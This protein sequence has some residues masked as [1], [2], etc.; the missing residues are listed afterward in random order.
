[1]RAS[2]PT[3][4]GPTPATP[5]A[6]APSSASPSSATLATATPKAQRKFPAS[7]TT[8]PGRPS[9]WPHH[10]SPDHLAT[11]RGHAVSWFREN[12]RDLPMRRP[13]VSAWG[14]VVFEVMSQQ[15]PIPRVQPVWEKWMERWPTPAALAQARSG[16]ILVAWDRLGYPSRALRL[17]ECASYIVEHCEGTVPALVDDLLQLPGIGPY[18]ASA[19][20]SFHY[21]QRVPVLDTNVRRVLGRIFAGQG[22]PT[23][24]SP[25]RP[26]VEF[27]WACLPKDAHDSAEWNV[28]IMEL[29]ALVCTAKNPSCQ[30]CPLAKDCAWK[31]LGHPSPAVTRKSQAWKGTD[32]QARGQVM[33]L[34]RERHSSGDDTP[35]EAGQAK[36]PLAT[37][38]ELLTAAT[39]PNAEKTQAQ[40][41]I[42]ALTRDGLIQGS[43]AT[44]FTLP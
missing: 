42:E 17:K 33:A 10:I 44:G 20:S 28:S 16:D 25:T 21:R 29:G 6:A 36:Y 39:L 18:T 23:S 19:V 30:A 4:G 13:E 15:T 8:S 31:T 37:Y 9:S 26:E 40:R 14:T 5:S 3:L 22:A 7:D 43:A 34:L 11:I 35:S 24:S 38:E 2:A 1:M 12:G 32:R 27:A 41:V